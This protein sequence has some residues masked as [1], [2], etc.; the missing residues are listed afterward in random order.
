MTGT[1]VFVYSSDYLKYSFGRNHPLNPIRLETT[2]DLLTEMGLLDEKDVVCPRMAEEEE[3]ALV[4]SPEYINAVV[5]AGK[6]PKGG[7]FINYELGTEDNPIFE[8]MHEAASLIAGGTL[9]A[10]EAVVEGKARH[11][12]NIAGGLHH[13]QRDK[14]SGFCIYNDAAVAIAYLRKKYDLRVM[15]IDT[16]AHHGDGVQDIFYD[17][18]DVLV[19]SLHESGH[20]LFPGTGDIYEQGTGLGYGTTINIPFEPFTEDESWISAFERVVIPN[21]R[22]FAPHIIISQHG[23]DGHHLDPLTHLSLTMKSYEE[24]PRLVHMLAEQLC[25]GRLVALGGGGYNIWQVVPRAWAFLW[26]QIAQRNA[27]EKLP[28]SWVK[29]WESISGEKLPKTMSD[30][31]DLV[32]P[33]P[34]RKEIIEKNYITMNRVLRQSVM[35]F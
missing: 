14:A 35:F 11:A 9:T 34:R 8:G 19:V 20:Y 24:I 13:A 3:L 2:Y 10:V 26:C 33:I 1:A 6:N 17:D 15:Y 7:D 23:C 16:D 22:A 21:A 12:V 25:E 31:P 29:K 4:H 18:P 30:P 27:H 28:E 5:E 32:P